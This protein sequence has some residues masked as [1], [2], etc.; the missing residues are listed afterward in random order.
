MEISSPVVDDVTVRTVI[1]NM[2][3]QDW[4]SEVLDFLYGDMEDEVYMTCPEGIELVEDGW[5]S[6]EDCTELL[7]TVSVPIKQLVNTG[8]N[9]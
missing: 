4:E 9:L 5:N 2:L 7:R 1:T 6:E 8:R 3:I